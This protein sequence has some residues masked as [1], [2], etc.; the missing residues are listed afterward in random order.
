MIGGT[1]ESLCQQAMDVAMEKVAQVVQGLISDYDLNPNLI[2][3]VGR[4]AAPPPWWPLRWVRGWASGTALPRT[5]RTS[6]TI[7]V[8]LAL[9]R[10][11]IERNVS[12]PTDEDIRKIRH[13]VMEV[14]TRA[15]ADAA[16][17]DIAIE[18]DSQKNILRATATGR[19]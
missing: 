15:G 5:P 3:L 19:H 2:Y 9:V 6:S 12:N 16:T 10:E 7:G 1:A 8:S 18:I 14:V 13:D 17:V 11:Q 4:A